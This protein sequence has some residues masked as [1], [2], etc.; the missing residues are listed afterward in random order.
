[1]LYLEECARLGHIPRNSSSSTTY[2]R[3]VLLGKPTRLK[4][5]LTSE[6]KWNSPCASVVGSNE[7]PLY[8]SWLDRLG[9]N[10]H[11]FFIGSSLF[12]IRPL[13]N[14]P[15]SMRQ[16]ITPYNHF[17]LFFFFFFFTATPPKHTLSLCSFAIWVWLFIWICIWVWWVWDLDLE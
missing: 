13:A 1:M 5:Y 11:P 9:L 6:L 7:V 10:G 12:F 4:L 17:P 14:R 2:L 16:L 3:Q 15:I 8:D